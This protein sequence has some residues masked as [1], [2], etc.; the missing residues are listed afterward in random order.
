VADRNGSIRV[1]AVSHVCLS[2]EITLWSLILPSEGSRDD[3]LL[4]SDV[5][6]LIRREVGCKRLDFMQGNCRAKTATEIPSKG[7]ARSNFNGS[8]PVALA[9]FTRWVTDRKNL[10]SVED[11]SPKTI[12]SIIATREPWH[13]RS[14]SFGKEELSVCAKSR[15]A[16][17]WRLPEAGN[18]AEGP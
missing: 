18:R 6:T 12:H 5:S 2:C 16:G 15:L 10:P 17:K 1:A 4:Q 8:C 14:R 9:V 11:H 13:S 7:G 3:E